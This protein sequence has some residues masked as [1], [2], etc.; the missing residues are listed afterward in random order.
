MTVHWYTKFIA[1]SNMIWIFFHLSVVLVYHRIG[2]KLIHWSSLHGMYAL[3]LMSWHEAIISI[4]SCLHF[5]ALAKVLHDDCVKGHSDWLY[6]QALSPFRADCPPPRYPTSSTIGT[7]NK[8]GKKPCAYGAQQYGIAQYLHKIYLRISAIPQ[9][10][11]IINK[12]VLF[13]LIVSFAVE[14]DI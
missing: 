10:M 7:I 11:L 4:F 12:M 2:S 13:C 1:V 5:C 8:K 3:F 6:R 9:H 14:D